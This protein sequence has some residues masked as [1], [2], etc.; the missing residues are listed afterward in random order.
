MHLYLECILTKPDQYL[1]FDIIFFNVLLSSLLKILIMIE[2]LRENN[3]SI[4]RQI[5][6][7]TVIMA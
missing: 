3:L 7:L 1:K 6:L 5:I 2:R 4:R